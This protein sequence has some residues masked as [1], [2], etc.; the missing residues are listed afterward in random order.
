MF[1]VAQD[2]EKSDDEDEAMLDVDIV[3]HTRRIGNWR[4]ARRELESEINRLTQ[5]VLRLRLK[6]KGNTRKSDEKLKELADE[7]ARATQRPIVAIFRSFGESLPHDDVFDAE[8]LETRRKLV[9]KWTGIKDLDLFCQDSAWPTKIRAS[10]PKPAF[11]NRE[12]LLIFFICFRRGF[13]FSQL[14]LLLGLGRKRTTEIFTTVLAKLVQWSQRHVRF[15]DLA[16]WAS[17]RSHDFVT[18]YGDRAYMIILD[19]TVLPIL[20]PAVGAIRRLFWNPKHSFLAK[21]VTIAITEDGG[22]VWLSRTVPG[23]THDREAINASD[24]RTLLRD[25]YLDVMRQIRDGQMPRL[26]LMIA[27]DKGYP[28][29]IIPKYWTLHL[30]KTAKNVPYRQPPHDPHDDPD[31]GFYCPKRDEIVMD[32]RLAHFRQAAEGAIADLK[33]F[34]LLVNPQFVFTHNEV[35]DDCIQVAGGVIN[36]NKYN[37]H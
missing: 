24:F 22:F 13:S 4:R 25:H 1:C 9:F 16:M 23:L 30:T 11:N 37:V 15:P 8:V 35:L 36:F 20:A 27:G 21:C 18:V 12:Q 34:E 17:R 32:V 31:F 5:E 10:G 6:L 7:N 3:S 28:G 26:H 19:G 29:M 2:E 33:D 14:K